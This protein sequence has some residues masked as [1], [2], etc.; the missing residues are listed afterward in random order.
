MRSICISTK[1]QHFLNVTAFW[2]MA[3]CSLVDVDHGNATKLFSVT[4]PD[5]KEIIVVY[6]ENHTTFIN[7][8]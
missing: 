6:S 3:L 4:I 5:V 7:L 2:D 1:T 8:L